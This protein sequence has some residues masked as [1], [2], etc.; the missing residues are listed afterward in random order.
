[1]YG[2]DVGVFNENKRRKDEVKSVTSLPTSICRKIK[3]KMN[4]SR[5]GVR[6]A[7]ILSDIIKI[8]FPVCNDLMSRQ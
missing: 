3:M 5:K 8:F 1:M 4:V 6:E 7:T 2:R